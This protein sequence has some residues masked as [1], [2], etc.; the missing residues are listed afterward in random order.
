MERIAFYRSHP[1]QGSVHYKVGDQAL[2]D[3]LESVYGNNEVPLGNTLLAQQR[4]LGNMPVWSKWFYGCPQVQGTVDGERIILFDDRMVDVNHLENHPLLNPSFL[5]DTWRSISDGAL[6]VSREYF[7]SLVELSAN[8]NSGV[9]KLAHRD[10]KRI[11]TL[12]STNV[13][14]TNPYFA[15]FTGL[16]ERERGEYLKAHEAKHG[17]NI[18]LH[19]ALAD[20]KKDPATGRLSVFDGNYFLSGDL[21]LSYG[22]ARLFGVQASVA[23]SSAE[24]AAKKEILAAYLRKFV[25]EACLEQCLAG[26]PSE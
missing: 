6:P 8:T 13:A 17:K 3:A 4:A 9:R 25:P 14:M 2:I 7:M 26:I 11:N 18:G 1:L 16:S 12:I 20:A 23:S 19:C 15:A 10:L 21:D 5:R 22:Y 24:G